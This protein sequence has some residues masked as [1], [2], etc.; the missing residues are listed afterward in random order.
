MTLINAEELAYRILEETSDKDETANMIYGMVINAPT[1]D[2]EPVRHG[3]WVG[4]DD[5]PCDAWE[6][7]VCGCIYEEAQKWRPLY[8]PNCGAR[9]EVE[10]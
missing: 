2:A 10:K 4:I 6:C 7:D 9:M 5:E 3:H 8:C 1:I